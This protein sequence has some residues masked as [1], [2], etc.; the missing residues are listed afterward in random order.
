M[1]T[2][3]LVV[4]GPMASGKSTVGRLLAERLGRPLRDSDDDL[5]V[6]LGISGRQLAARDGVDALHRWEA[7]HLLRALADPTPAVVAA[8]ASTVDDARC[9]AALGGH[10]VVALVALRSVLAARLSEAGNDAGHRR[11]VDPGEG[12]LAA[13]RA[14]AFR[15]VADIV[16]DVGDDPP[17][18]VAGAVLGRPAL[19][20]LP[21][22]SM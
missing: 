21:P 5:V 2:V 8:A 14:A 17:D 15:S 6:E 22:G 18:A 1:E 11:P 10:L 9:R 16:V 13:R 4:V 7:D 20:R 3:H 19:E 12:D